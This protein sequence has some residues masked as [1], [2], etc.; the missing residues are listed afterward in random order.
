[1]KF[2]IPKMDTLVRDKNVLY[3]IFFLA[4]FNV[5]GYLTV[6]NF[7]A[8]I[9]FLVVGFLTTYF[10]KNMIVVL[11]VSMIVTNIFVAHKKVRRE[12][13]EN[14]DDDKKETEETEDDKKEKNKQQVK[15]KEE[16]PVKSSIASASTNKVS[17]DE[18]TDHDAEDADEG[19]KSS[20]TS[21]TGKKRLDMSDTL[22]KA[23]SKLQD[24]VGEEGIE[25]LTKKS[26]A[27]L[28]Q[29]KDLMDNINTIKPFLEKAEMFMDKMDFAKIDGL[30]SMLQNFV[31]K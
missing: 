26:G 27:L 16:E 25:G 31:G 19:V 13:M 20:S 18:E 24:H 11:L 3:V 30:T 5:L 29:Q 28:N 14:K 21:S 9:M 15:D 2:E 22:E 6:S 8:V 10:S 1:M 23:Y 7:D 4:V 12:G 17:K